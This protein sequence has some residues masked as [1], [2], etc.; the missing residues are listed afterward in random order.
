MTVASRH[1]GQLRRGNLSQTYYN[2]SPADLRR[3]GLTAY[4]SFAFSDPDV[5]HLSCRD[6]FL[7]LTPR[8][9]G[10]RCCMPDVFCSSC[11]TDV[12]RSGVGKGLMADERIWRVDRVSYFTIFHD[13]Y[14]AFYVRLQYA[15]G[16]ATYHLLHNRTGKLLKVLFIVQMSKTRTRSSA[17]AEIARHAS[18]WSRY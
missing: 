11:E 12:I 2:R 10:V 14:C 5:N 6:G 16:G 7:V 3:L 8:R 18:R 15:V 17:G 4:Q 13:D 9:T 1:Y